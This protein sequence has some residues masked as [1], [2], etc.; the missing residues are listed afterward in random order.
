[1]DDDNKYDLRLFEEVITRLIFVGNLREGGG[2]G[3]CLI[4]SLERVQVF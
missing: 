3:K 1:M 4:K 2:G